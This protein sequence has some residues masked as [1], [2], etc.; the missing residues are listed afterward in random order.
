MLGW[1]L[2]WARSRAFPLVDHVD[3]RSGTRLDDVRTESRAPGERVIPATDDRDPSLRVL[4]PGYAAHLEVIEMSA[5]M[6]PWRTIGASTWCFVPMTPWH[7]DAWK[8]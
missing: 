6:M 8:R 5:D 4:A 7:L 2:G 3:H 1:A